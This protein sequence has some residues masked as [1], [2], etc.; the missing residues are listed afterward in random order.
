MQVY[1]NHY[2]WQFYVFM[3]SYEYCI[4]IIYLMKL[5]MYVDRVC[6]CNAFISLSFALGKLTFS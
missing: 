3:Y 1:C 2:F 5:T 6:A 4:V